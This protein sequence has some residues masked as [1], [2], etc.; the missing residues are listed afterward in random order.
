MTPPPLHP[1]LERWRGTAARALADRTERERRLITGLAVIAGIVLWV[2]L[3]W[4]PLQ[5]ASADARADLAVA[6]TIVALVRDDPG[7]PRRIAADA[8]S[9]SATVTEAAA[10]A[11]VAIARVEP[12]G[13]ATRVTFEAV[14]FDPLVALID[15]IERSGGLRVTEIDI[16]RQ[17]APGRVNAVVVLAR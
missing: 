8:G 9:P 11:G 1:S 12:A 16:D 10:R 7:L 6:D 17:T 4:R 13:D 14:A 3:I 2:F 5:A 15:G